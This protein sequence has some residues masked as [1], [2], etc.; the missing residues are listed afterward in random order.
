[1]SVAPERV[2]TDQLVA[3]E[4]IELGELSR[5]SRAARSALR[6]PAVWF[7]GALVAAAIVGPLVAPYGPTEV[8]P[9]IQLQAP[10]SAHWF[11]TD[12][13]GMDVFSRVLHGARKDFL[14]AFAAAAL[15]AAIGAPL[16]TVAGLVGGWLDAALQRA[17]EVIQAFPVVL[18]AMAVLIAVGVTLTNLALVIAFINVPV[19]FRI[20]RSIVLPMRSADFVAAARCTGNSSAGIIVRHLLPNVSA[21]VIAQFSVNFAWAI[22]I[23]AGLSF[24]GLG[25]RV[26]EPEWGLMVQQGASYVVTGEWW[27]A[28]FP[29]AAI[30]VSVL[31]LNRLGAWIQVAGAVR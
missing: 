6:S 9:A 30:F 21:P 29:G 2:P 18:L 22:Q 13:L 25:V 27:I 26:P 12:S 31:A 4:E 17:T 15:A 7:S 1:V 20:V 5:R 3:A 11:G 24:L 23:I 19:Y 14:L 10:S 16:G 8:D 28:F